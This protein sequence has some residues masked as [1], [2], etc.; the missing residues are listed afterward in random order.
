[1][2]DVD[3][4][5][6]GSEIVVTLK[7]GKDFSDTWIVIHGNDASEVRQK[8]ADMFG[9]AEEQHKELKLYE[10]VIY[11]NKALQVARNLNVVL[12]AVPADGPVAP[13]DEPAKPAA[14][15]DP[16]GD[17]PQEDP[18]AK[19]PTTRTR[20]APAKEPEPEPKVDVGAL[21]DVAESVDSLKAIFAEHK[22][23]ITATPALQK[24]VKD[25]RAV[26]AG[27]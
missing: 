13:W 8:I 27:K 2:S 14:D 21:I 11:A 23:E 22:A 15:G 7:G 3:I 17:E 12:G 9:L 5:P 16:W 25:R 20:K 10:L 4:T 18:A 19:K 24:R 26:I 1:M 6:D